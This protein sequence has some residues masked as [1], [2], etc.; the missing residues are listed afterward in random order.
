MGLFSRKSTPEPADPNRDP[1]VLPLRAQSLLE[2]RVE[3]L[4]DRYRQLTRRFDRLQ[5]EFSSLERWR[6]EEEAVDEELDDEEAV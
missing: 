2:Q 3:V 5:G 1:L 6:A 4:E